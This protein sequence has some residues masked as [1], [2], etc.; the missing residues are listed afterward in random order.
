MFQ[1]SGSSPHHP[2][3]KIRSS[4]W[5]TVR[6]AEAIGCPRMREVDFPLDRVKD[7]RRIGVTFWELSKKS[8]KIEQIPMIYLKGMMDE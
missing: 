8:S 5:Q 4:T 1:G 2:P 6:F 3:S 7:A